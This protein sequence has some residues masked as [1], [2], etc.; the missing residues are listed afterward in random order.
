MK[1]LT[2]LSLI[3]FSFLAFGQQVPPQGI[4]FQA[5]LFDEFGTPVPSLNENSTLNNQSAEATFT[6]YSLSSGLNYYSE[7]HSISTD[8]YGRFQVV[9]GRGTPLGSNTF[10]DIVWSDGNIFLD[11]EVELNGQSKRLVSSQELLSVPY[12]LL[13]EKAMVAQT[14]VDVDDADA[15]PLNELQVLSI[16]GDSLTLSNGNTIKMP[17]TN[18][19]DADP[20]NE[21]Q[22][23]SISSDTI[24]L[25]NG[26]YAVLPP[27][28]VNDADADPSNEIQTITRS[29]TNITLSGNGGSITV[30][31]G[32][33]SSLTNTPSIPTNTSDLTNDSGFLTTEV[34]GSTTNELQV[35]SLSNDTI[36]LTSGGYVVLPAGFDGDYSSLTNTPSI[37]TNTSDLTNDSGFLTTEVDGSTTNELQVLSISNDT[38]SL[39]G[40][41]FI[42]LPAAGSTTNGIDLQDVLSEGNNAFNM[43][44]LNIKRQSIGQIALD[45]SAVLD[46][47]STTQGFL[48][49]RM[50]EAQR[51]AIYLPAAGLI[52][53]C[54]DCGPGGELQVFN[55]TAY[56]NMLGG[57][58]VSDPFMNLTQLGA[59]IDG[60]AAGD[61]SGSSVSLSADGT[62]LAIGAPHNKPNPFV[63]TNAIFGHVRIYQYSGG[64]WTQLGADIEGEYG[65]N[66]SGAGDAISLS[67]DGLTLAIGNTF[68]NGNGSN[69]GHVRIY[70]YSAGSWTQLGADIDGEAEN[71]RSGFSVSLSSDGTRVAIGAPANDGNGF[72]AGHVR[73]YEYSS[74]SWSQLGADIDG[75]VG[76]YISGLPNGDNSGYSV[77]L[78]S[79][80]TTVAI[81]A[82]WNDGNGNSAG[83][84]RIYE[85][86]SG[87]WTQLGADIDGEAFADMSGWSVSLSSD[88]TRVA[89]GARLNDGAGPNAGHV[90][91]YEYSSGSWSQ[92]GADIDGEA[93]SDGSGWSV[94]LSSDGTTVAIG[95]PWND[96]NGHVRIYKYLNTAWTNAWSQLGADID[97]EA[98][99]DRS[100]NSVSLSSDGTTVAI[101]AP[102]NDGTGSDAG[103][104]RVYK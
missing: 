4:N 50:T 44:V 39:S 5:V 1:K 94:S 22:V 15:D 30:F 3:F 58:A 84:V 87:S 20:L 48:P 88:G 34:D 53:W 101:G 49:P 25:S 60:E 59:D 77:S 57:P 100:G 65:N 35:L 75:E 31:D 69:S 91:I 103:H 17:V 62:I 51:D 24:F 61:E 70:E 71:D 96:G 43:A 68:N 13:A 82:P 42:K 40:G 8:E 27:D 80:G 45:T 32:D 63:S 86:S 79:D 93:A 11:F 16:T 23:L 92:L 95:T 47:A 76:N 104:V 9:L 83:H 14:A 85:Y 21:I 18:D 52:V 56:T 36:Y 78:S 54:T 46:V 6:F 73:I 37:P 38:I 81:G 28:Q 12:A 29:G 98:G 74:G 41:G 97:G 72:D 99:G 55:G 89:I 2:L 26:G 90:R 64:S 33:Y 102:Y 19:A 10:Q 7:T 66:F 67:A